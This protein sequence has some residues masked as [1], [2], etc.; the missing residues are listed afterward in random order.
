MLL[1]LALPLFAQDQQQMSE[2]EQRDWLVQL[3]ESQLSTPERQIQLSNIDGVL[4]SEVSI[5]EITISDEEGVWLRINNAALNWNQAAL[6]TGRLE[7]RS[8][9]A[10]S[11][12]FIR[13]AVPAEGAADLPQP[14]AGALAIPEFPVAVILED[15]S[16]PSVSFGEDVFGLGSEISLAGAMTLDGGNLDANLDIVRLDGPGGTLALDL[17]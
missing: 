13:N 2:A 15:L 17:A 7:V 16:V 9:T 6:F 4:G 3:V 14:E 11:I 1:A 12:Q 5:R 8:L 10:D